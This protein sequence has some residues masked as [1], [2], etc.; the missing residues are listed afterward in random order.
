MDI[1]K[2][3]IDWS[4]AE[5]VSSAFFVVFGVVFLVAGLGFWQLGKTDVAKAFVIPA[6]VAGTL[7]VILGAG[8]LF[9]NQSRLAGFPAA[10]NKDASAFIASEIDRVDKTMKEY[11]TAVFLVIPIIIAVCSMLIIFL[12]APLWRAIMITTIAMMAVILIVDTN[13]NG[14]LEAYKG[15]LLSAAKQE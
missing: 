8:L 14:R 1:L 6:L 9:S 2:T 11:G 7:L 13:A 15:Q 5:M 10:Y 4:K 3:A 12:D